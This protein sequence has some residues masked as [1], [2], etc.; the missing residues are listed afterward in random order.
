MTKA[1]T[2]DELLHAA[3]ATMAPRHERRRHLATF[4][5]TADHL[6]TGFRDRSE[7]RGGFFMP[8]RPGKDRLTPKQLDERARR[9]AGELIQTMAAASK[10][11]SRNEFIRAFDRRAPH[12]NRSTASRLHVDR[13]PVKERALKAYLDG[14]ANNAAGKSAN[15]KRS[16]FHPDYL[17]RDP[18]HQEPPLALAA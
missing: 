8:Q 11:M 9:R 18:S 2:I 3:G 1:M 6:R 17:R 10:V 4:R 14:L 7:Y 16:L 15:G 12:A 13:E 5:R